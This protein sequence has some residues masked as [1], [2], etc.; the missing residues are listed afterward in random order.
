MTQI[1]FL[2][3][4]FLA[5]E[6]VIA[7][8]TD[9]PD[10]ECPQSCA[11][12]NEMMQE[13]QALR[14]SVSEMRSKQIDLESRQRGV[15]TRQASNVALLNSTSELLRN[16]SAKQLPCPL[17]FQPNYSLKSCYYFSQSK[18][19][20][21]QARQRCLDMQAYLVEVE[22]KEEDDFIRATVAARG[23]PYHWLGGSDTLHEGV[24]RWSHSGRAFTYTNWHTRQPDNYKNQEDCILTWTDLKWNDGG[25]Q[26]VTYFICEAN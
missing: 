10:G 5:I 21:H 11:L 13:I 9:F 4:L 2:C 24:F 3:V 20:W 12:V 14:A 17:R 26:H 25:C 18:L 19:N 16:V 8:P 23:S 15:E 7:Q 22:S 6:V 1:Q